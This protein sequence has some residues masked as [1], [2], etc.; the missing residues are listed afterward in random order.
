MYLVPMLTRLM[1]V[2][3]TLKMEKVFNKNWTSWYFRGSNIKKYKSKF[4]NWKKN[5]NKI[6]KKNDDF[7]F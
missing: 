7:V 1:T 2:K 3:L 6:I 5:F 4:Y